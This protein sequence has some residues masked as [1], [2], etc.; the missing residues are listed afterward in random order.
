MKTIVRKGL[1]A[2]I[3]SL[4]TVSVLAAQTTHATTLAQN[5]KKPACCKKHHCKKGMKKCMKMHKKA[6][7]AEADT[8]S[9]QS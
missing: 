4:F 9:T 8:T 3:A 7:A 6:K 1:V 2:L 5:G